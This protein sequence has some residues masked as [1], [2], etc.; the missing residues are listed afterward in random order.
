M[1]NC[2]SRGRREEGVTFG[3]GAFN[4]CGYG[5]RDEIRFSDGVVPRELAP[6]RDASD[7]LG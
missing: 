4:G 2:A 7:F 5:G 6:R 1:Q 3:V